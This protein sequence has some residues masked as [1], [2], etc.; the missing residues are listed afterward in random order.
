MTIAVS[1]VCGQ[2]F[3]ETAPVVRGREEARNSATAY[4]FETLNHSCRNPSN[5]ESVDVF[6]DKVKNKNASRSF[7]RWEVQMTMK[8][9]TLREVQKEGLSVFS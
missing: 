4:I 5:C 1:V 3:S 8:Q 9:I 6:A 7:G 2:Q